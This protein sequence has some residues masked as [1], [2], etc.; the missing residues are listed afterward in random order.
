MEENKNINENNLDDLLRENF[1]ESGDYLDDKT[2]DFILKQEYD[3]PIN[4]AKEKK[5]M[6]QLPPGDSFWG[7]SILIGIIIA[8]I[9]VLIIYFSTKDSNNNTKDREKYKKQQ[10]KEQKKITVSADSSSLKLTTSVDGK[11][12]PLLL[13]KTPA[14]IVTHHGEQA[15][16]EIP[17]YVQ[18]NISEI[19]NVLEEEYP[20]ISETEKEKYGKIKQMMLDKFL[21]TEK[22]LYTPVE[23][24][25]TNYMGK[26]VSV[27]AFIMRN[28]QVTNLEYRTFLMDLL[29]KDKKE[30]YNKAKINARIW[31]DYSLNGLAKTYHTDEKYNDFP[32]VNVSIEGAL[33]YCTWLETEVNKYAVENKIKTK[34]FRIRLPK[35][36]EWIN[37]VA[38]GYAFMPVCNGY[39]TLYEIKEG[40]VDEAFLKRVATIKK[41]KKKIEEVDVLYSTNRYGMGEKEITDIYNKAYPYYDPLPADTIH[42]KRMNRYC[43]IGHVSEMTYEMRSGNIMV[44]GC[45]W[46]NKEEYQKMLS[47]FHKANASP[48]VG[49]R[50]VIIQEGAAEYK[51]PF[52]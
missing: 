48:F 26:P 14:L 16:R 51:N 24:W 11:K 42:A 36:V 32:V 38:V 6:K 31:N 4:P 20:V 40:Y 15:T 13:T 23:A 50:P 47:E 33:L 25:K 5:M 9:A 27:D 10:E 18:F 37:S 44:V 45:C 19:K 29:L 21:K 12:L 1:L 17:E 3:V 8:I 46:K 49:F 39:N 30:E 22:D 41:R 2:A 28:M 43:E 35:D 34:P 7:L 52:W